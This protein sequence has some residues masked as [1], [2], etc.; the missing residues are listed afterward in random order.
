MKHFFR[1]RIPAEGRILLIESGSRHLMEDLL[2]RRQ[3]VLGEGLQLDLV[4]CYDGVP[5]GFDESAGKVY[6]VM[7]Y[8]GAPGRKVLY[9]ELEARRYRIA[10]VICSAEPIMTKWKWMLGARLPVKVLILNENADFFWCDHSNWRTIRHFFLFRMGLT[11]AGAVRTA[12]GMLL[13]PLAL[14]YLL[15]NT[16][17]IH[18]R[19]IVHT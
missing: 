13:F 5:R 9:R 11:G 12:A 15:L 16:A 4:T 17:W 8:S 2:A 14:A 18:V 7:D 1:R 6:R 19:R 10:V 3:D